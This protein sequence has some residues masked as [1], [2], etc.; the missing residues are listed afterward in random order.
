MTTSKVS[1][2]EGNYHRHVTVVPR[3]H[4][5]HSKLRIGV[6]QVENCKLPKHFGTPPIG[7]RALV[8][9]LIEESWSRVSCSLLNFVVK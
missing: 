7:E 1:Q 3:F 9:D 8:R 6:V 2:L 5:K 4:T